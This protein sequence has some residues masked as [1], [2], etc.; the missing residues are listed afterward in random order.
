MVTSRGDSGVVAKA[1]KTIS[2]AVVGLFVA[3]IS[4]VIVNFVASKI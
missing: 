3:M 2:H 4:F 1:M